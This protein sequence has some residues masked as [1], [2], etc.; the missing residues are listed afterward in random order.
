MDFLQ[1]TG[2]SILIFGVANRKSVAWHIGRVLSEAGAKCVYVVQNE[3]RAEE[4]RE[5]ARR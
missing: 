4:R 3:E 5:A 1:L 2:K